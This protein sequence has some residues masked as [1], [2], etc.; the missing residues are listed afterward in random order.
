LPVWRDRIFVDIK[1]KQIFDLLNVV[2]DKHGAHM[3]DAVLAVLRSMAAYVQ[4]SD[5][6]YTPP[7]IRGMSRVPPEDRKRE[8]VLTDAEITAVWRA[9]GDAG[10]YGAVIKMLLLT[11]QRR[12]KVLRMKWSDVS[13]DGVWTIATEKREKPN[14][15]KL[16]LPEAALTVLRGLPRFTGK[17]RVFAYGTGNISHQKASF[18]KKC[19][20]T[21]WQAARDLRRTARTLMSRAGVRRDIGERVLG[22]LQGG[23]VERIYDRHDY[24]DEKADALRRLAAL[25][26]IITTGKPTDDPAALRA[27]IDAMVAAPSKVVKLR[28]RRAA[29]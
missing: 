22:H 27:E 15:V 17:A 3:A 19:G 1:R 21:G 5:D 20:V 29:S 14:A 12:A 24:A 28:S 10:V 13:A 8:R 9:A 6:N 11:G 7:F 25:I 18:D 16:R 26:E 2:E 23:V 4:T